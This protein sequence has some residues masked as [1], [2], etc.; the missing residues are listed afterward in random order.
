MMVYYTQNHLVS[1]F[2][3]FDHRPLLK[4]LESSV[5]ETGSVSVPG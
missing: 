2:L 1:G 3:E 5:S 4:N